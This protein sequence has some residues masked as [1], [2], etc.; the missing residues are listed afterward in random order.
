MKFTLSWLKEFL[1]TDVSL[2]LI[3]QSLTKIGLEVEEIIDKTTTLS[4]F[5]VAFIKEATIHPEADGL[6]FY[7]LFVGARMRELV[8]K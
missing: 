6:K 1:D 4:P 7:K 5:I 2:E 8:L 3:A